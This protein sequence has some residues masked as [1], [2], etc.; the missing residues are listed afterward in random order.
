MTNAT[1]L[2]S[3][4]CPAETGRGPFKGNEPLAKLHGPECVRFLASRRR[5]QWK[6]SHRACDG[7]LHHDNGHSARLSRRRCQHNCQYIKFPE[8]L[9]S[10][11][12]SRNRTWRQPRAG[13]GHTSGCVPDTAYVSGGTTVTFD[14][15]PAPLFYVANRLIALQAPFTLS[16]GS[17]TRVQIVSSS[18][19]SSAVSLS[20]VRSKPGIFTIESGGRGQAK[21][22][23]QDGT[24][25]SERT[26]AAPGSVISVMAQA[27]FRWIRPSRPVRGRRPTG[28]RRRYCPSRPALAGC[29]RP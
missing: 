8:R 19:S 29:R 17:T 4:F 16:P 3:D 25:N 1:N 26:P 2:F 27:S 5:K 22:V 18:G 7:L 11:R 28:Y 12:R 6:R 14:G 13:S 21:A 15:V 24:M 23:N 9:D 20:V 10:A